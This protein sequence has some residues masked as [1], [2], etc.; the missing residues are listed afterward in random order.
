MTIEPPSTFSVAPSCDELAMTLT[1]SNASSACNQYRR[2]RAA[3]S[4]SDSAG[5]RIALEFHSGLLS[6]LKE[7][8]EPAAAFAQANAPHGTD[9]SK[10][11]EDRRDDRTCV[12][13]SRDHAL[14]VR[15][16]ARTSFA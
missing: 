6:A 13:R 12:A 5:P 9:Y 1:S 2:E 16:A 15:F 14:A 10:T 8:Q 3:A 4:R 11:D 7:S